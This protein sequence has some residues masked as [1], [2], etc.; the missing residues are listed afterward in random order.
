MR[1]LL[2]T[3]RAV[4]ASVRRGLRG[5]GLSVTATG[6]V[7][8]A[9][10]ELRKSACRVVLLDQGHLRAPA[11]PHLLR[12][13]REGVNAR[14]LV[15]LPANASGEDKA[16]CLD[17]GA[18]AC[19]LHPLSSV[20]LRAQLRA[21]DRRDLPRPSPTLQVHDLKLDLSTRE[22]TRADRR[23]HVTAREYDLLCLLASRPG[24]VFSR[25]AILEHMYEGQ[26][27]AQS[28]VVDVYVRYLRN[29][30]DRGFDP[31]LILTRWG[32]GY[33]LRPESGSKSRRE[34]KGR[35]GVR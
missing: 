26:S 14:L 15:L 9:D 31:P 13:R 12:W 28:N 10:R 1:L 17:A 4:A 19:L 27:G 34:G 23:I 30:I 7:E 20:E 16:A 21:L 29:K 3:G 6:R 5:Q 25:E 18:D 22:V 11:V 8:Q 32:Q 33:Y 2:V 24:T 35:E